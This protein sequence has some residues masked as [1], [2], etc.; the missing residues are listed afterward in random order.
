MAILL[1]KLSAVETQNALDTHALSFWKL[2]N[3]AITRTLKTRDWRATM[4][5]ANAI[6][7]LCETAWHH[8]RLTLTYSEIVIRL[9]THDVG[10]VSMRDIE[11][12]A[13]IETW[14]AWNGAGD[15]NVLE[16]TPP[17]VTLLRP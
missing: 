12:A 6:A 9:D 17:L 14:L 16:G 15:G 2:E 5:V 8:P 10:G 1:K 11:L 13:Q 7:Y 4:M 3:D